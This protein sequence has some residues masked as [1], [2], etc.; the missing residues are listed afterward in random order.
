MIISRMVAEDSRNERVRRDERIR[1][2][3]MG[4]LPWQ[5]SVAIEHAEREGE[6]ERERDMN[7]HK[8][9]RERA[10]CY[11]HAFFNKEYFN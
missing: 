4:C 3:S 5:P 6:R 8:I 2:G 11:I 7:I 10:S 9:K 1:T